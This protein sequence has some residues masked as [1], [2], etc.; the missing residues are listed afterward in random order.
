METYSSIFAWEKSCGQ[1][2]LA[3]YN[4]LGHKES[5]TTERQSTQIP[6]RYSHELRTQ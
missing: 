3:G 2:S 5:D 4:P 1:E 6:I